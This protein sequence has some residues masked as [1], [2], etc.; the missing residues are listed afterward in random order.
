[1]QEDGNVALYGDNGQFC[2]W[3][4]NTGGDCVLPHPHRR[5][6]QNCALNC[7]QRPLMCRAAYCLLLWLCPVCTFLLCH[8][9]LYS[10]CKDAHGTVSPEGR[11]RG[12]GMFHCCKWFYVEFMQHAS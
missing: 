3:A 12:L 9:L 1:M 11:W 2:G 10:C 7:H 4:T 8:P 6:S 5:L